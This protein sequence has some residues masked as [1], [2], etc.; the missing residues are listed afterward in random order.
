MRII[1]APDSYKGSLSAVE[2]ATSRTC[3]LLRLGM[4]IGSQ[5]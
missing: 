5:P 3:R 2:A 1:V 4:E